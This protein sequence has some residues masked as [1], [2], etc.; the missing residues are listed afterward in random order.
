LCSAEVANPGR[1]NVRAGEKLQLL[2]PR[3]LLGQSEAEITKWRH[4]LLEA[5]GPNS[6]LIADLVPELKLKALS[7]AT[8]EFIDYGLLALFIHH[9]HSSR[10]RSGLRMASPLATLSFGCILTWLHH[11]HMERSIA[12]PTSPFRIHQMLL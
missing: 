9:Q 7:E 1:K 8:A 11:H 3:Q 6:L 10:Y 12:R 2:R 5:L 4:D